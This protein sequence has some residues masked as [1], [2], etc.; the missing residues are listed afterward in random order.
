MFTTEKKE[1]GRCEKTLLDDISIMFGPHI[2]DVSM[3]QDFYCMKRRQYSSAHLL[4]VP[5]QLVGQR[6]LSR[7][8][9]RDDLSAHYEVT[10]QA[11]LG[12]PQIHIGRWFH[13]HWLRELK[14]VYRATNEKPFFLH[15]PTSSNPSVSQPDSLQGSPM[16]AVTP[17]VID[18]T[19]CVTLESLS[20]EDIDRNGRPQ[21][22]WRYRAHGMKDVI[23]FDKDQGIKLPSKLKSFEMIGQSADRFNFGLLGTTP[24]LECLQILGMKCRAESTASSVR[25]SLWY[26]DDVNLPSLKS[27]VIHH[28]P[29]QHFRFELLYRCTQLESL[30]IRDIPEDAFG[31]CCGGAHPQDTCSNRD[32]IAEFGN[33]TKSRIEVLR[34]PGSQSR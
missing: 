17:R 12:D 31:V 33:L 19:P 10:A 18:F 26:W 1:S 14:I 4:P 24:R 7:P 2:E 15:W 28:S 23:P 32:I 11:P 22:L 25:E 21:R 20:I 16:L 5:Q 9:G 8:S 3:T 34:T 29:A 30:D 13:L 27:L 6:L